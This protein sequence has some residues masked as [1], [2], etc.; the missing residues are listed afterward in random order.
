MLGKRIPK[1]ALTAIVLIPNVQAVSAAEECTFRKD[2]M[3]QEVRRVA[4][5]FPGAKINSDLQIASWEVDG[6]VVET[7]SASGCHDYGKLARRISSLPE[8]RS[9]DEVV[10]VAL[11]L[12]RKFMAADVFDVMHQALDAD[13]E[14][15]R[16][17]DEFEYV[18][19]HHMFGEILITH[20]FADGVDSI[21]VSWPVL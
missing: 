13:F 2:G 19:V 9:I 10:E 5:A 3:L 4:S 12:G 7:F 21:G 11:Q 17:S 1:F 18:I 6:Q 15:V 16:E 8:K 20:G 14:V